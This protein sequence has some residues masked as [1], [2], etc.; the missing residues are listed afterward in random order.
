[1]KELFCIDEFNEHITISREQLFILKYEK[2]LMY[3][4]FYEWTNSKTAFRACL[5]VSLS[6]HF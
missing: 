6:E 3:D 2:N 4:E 1:M 5:T